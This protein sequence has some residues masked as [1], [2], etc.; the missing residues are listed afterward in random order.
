MKNTIFKIIAL[1]ILVM[2]IKSCAAA[3][4]A[5]TTI[6]IDPVC[7]MKVDKS[8][9]FD[10]KYSGK[11][12]YFDAYECKETFKMNPQKFIDNKCVRRDSIK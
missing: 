7:G 6:Y 8:A 5:S 9:S 10:W 3:K 12:Y 4:P 2:I 11:T 1:S